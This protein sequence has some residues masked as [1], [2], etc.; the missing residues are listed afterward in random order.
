MKKLWRSLLIAGFLA[1]FVILLGHFNATKPRILVLHSAAR[2]S[3]WVSQMDAGMRKALQ[4]NRR[5][6]S[7][8]WMYMGVTSPSLRNARE[9]AAEAQRGIG[10]TDPDLLIA[11]DDEANALV[12]RDYVGRDTPRILY[13]SIDRPPAAYGYAGAPNVSGIADLLPWAA[14]RDV[15][16]DIF[17]ARADVAVV[18][19]DNESGRAELDQIRAFDWGPVT[20][21]RADLVASAPAWR[22]AVARA[23]GADA[24]IVLGA[25]ALPDGDGRLVS[26]AELSRWTEQNSRP[27]PIGTEVDFVTDGGALSLAPPPDNYGEQAIE[28][29]LDWLD[30]RRTPGPPPPVTS[31]HFEVALRQDLLA[32]RGVVLPPI[33]AEAARENGTLF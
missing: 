14:F 25:Q 23:D 21:G 7:V 32:R 18:G 11:V 10:R 19:V 2:D 1:T 4:R 15:L 31:S 17:G 29:A 28:L 16:T 3:P 33:Y 22:E 24:L 13:V 27:L 30:D 6:V 12:A 26:A 8:E 20:V 9:A 5:P